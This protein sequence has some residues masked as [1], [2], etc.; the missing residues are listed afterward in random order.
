MRRFVSDLIAGEMTRLRPTGFAAPA[1]PFDAT[2]S[3][4]DDLGL[5]SLELV[6]LASALNDIL[7]LHASGVE[8]R[9]L[10]QRRVGDWTATAIEGL[11]TY[12]DTL[13]F[14]TSGSS[15][16]P[17]R[18][19]HA[20]T[21]LYQEVT[22]LS[23]LFQD[24]RRV[25][26]AVRSHH[27]YGFLFTI[28]LPDVLGL[29][30]DAVVDARQMLPSSLPN[31]M[32][33][34][35]LIIGYPDFWRD[36]AR[37]PMPI[38]ADVIGVT[39]TAPCPDDVAR[40]LEQL[41][42]ARLVQV[43]GS[44]ETAGVGV[45]T[46]AAS[47]FELLRFWRRDEDG[48][49]DLVRTGSD[50]RDVIKQIP[51]ILAWEGDRHFRPLRRADDVVQVGGVNV[52]LSSVRAVLLHHPGVRDAAVRSWSGGSGDR[53]KAFVVPHET[54]VDTRLLHADLEGWIAERLPAA[55]RPRAISFG[56]AIPVNEQG[57]QIDWSVTTVES[58][59][60]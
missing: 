32:R 48:Q 18:C 41:G 38:P 7:H 43:Y 12:A 42:L 23:A 29:S 53:I 28:A 4:T 49:R 13:T 35:D 36:V 59:F 56:D 52:S 10:M 40:D 26:S 50:G 8:D 37:A 9:L 44:T 14:R 58:K 22:E 24:R 3:L 57:K 45:R 34:G 17:K 46:S 2:L 1:S 20:V 31:R 6:R 55:E 15:G 33:E 11:S 30:R 39:S 27:I 51:D 19:T 47:P 54:K 21:D 16:S 25:L 5:D 60:P